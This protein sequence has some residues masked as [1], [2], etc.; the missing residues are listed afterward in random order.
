MATPLDQ[1]QRS[2]KS[3]DRP[4]L[5][6]A[7][8]QSIIRAILND[9]IGRLIGPKLII[10][11][12]VSRLADLPGHPRHAETI[13]YINMLSDGGR[14]TT[15]SSTKL[16]KEH[17]LVGTLGVLERNWA[18]VLEFVDATVGVNGDKVQGLAG[19]VLRDIRV[20]KLITTTCNIVLAMN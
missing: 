8:C 17:E 1:T 16:L 12:L 3:L 5:R 7:L 20:G 9:I 11:R 13:K 6:S 2:S 18:L 10:I 19:P 14:L 15:P 4:R